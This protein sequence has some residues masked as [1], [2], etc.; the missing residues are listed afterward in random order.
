MNIKSRI[1]GYLFKLGF[2]L[3]ICIPQSQTF[4]LSLLDLKL[5]SFRPKIELV[6]YQKPDLKRNNLDY[7]S[8]KQYLSELYNAFD[9]TISQHFYCKEFLKLY[10]AC[11]KVRLDQNY[12][13][14]H[15]EIAPILNKK[16]TPNLNHLFKNETSTYSA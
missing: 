16:I 7:F 2:I 14:Y 1:Q 3:F 5:F 6:N 15:N 9:A 11:I 10:N 8:S 4:S 12:T 13:L